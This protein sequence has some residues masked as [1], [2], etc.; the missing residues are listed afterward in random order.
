MPDIPRTQ[1]TF[2]YS[3]TVQINYEVQGEGPVPFVFVHGFAAALT[4]WDD[5]RGMFPAERYRLYLLDLKGFGF[6]D[7]PKDGRYRPEDQAAIV[8]AF[9]EGLG[10]RRAVLAGHSL[11]GGIVLLAALQ[12][13]ATS[14]RELIG[15]LILIDCAAH[16][17]PLPRVMRWLR[18]P[19]VGPAILHLLPLRFMVLFTLKHVFHDRAA[20]TPE[21][22]ARYMGCFGMEGIGHVFI[23][24][25]RQLNPA[26]YAHQATHFRQI[27]VPTLIIWGSRD[28]II[29]PEHG[30]RLHAEIPG[31]RLAVIE[32]CGH[33][34]QEERP[35][36]TYEAI[37]E[38]LMTLTP[39]LSEGEGVTPP[40]PV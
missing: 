13:A 23:Q 25:C 30:E 12:A 9:L 1:H 8:L 34:P 3:P 22:I 17:Q 5:I 4:T 24:T 37:R 29:A 7:K 27:D 14:R 15:G 18:T 19:L 36:E 35:L 20:I 11:G 21:R 33:V 32:E 16:P 38:F 31:S 40:N 26:A 39:P 6:S 2:P 28:R 10:L